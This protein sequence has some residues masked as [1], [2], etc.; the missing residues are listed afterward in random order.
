[1]AAG[2]GLSTNMQAGGHIAAISGSDTGC[3]AAGKA[4]RF[5]K[6]KQTVMIESMV[7][8]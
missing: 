4:S 3:P 5:R 8:R 2:G 6:A 1:M 7:E